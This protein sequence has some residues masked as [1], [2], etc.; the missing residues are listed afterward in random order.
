[1][2]RL[3][4]LAKEG[5]QWES[6][7]DLWEGARSL[8]RPSLSVLEELAKAYEHRLHNL[9]EAMERAQ[10]GLRQVESRRA[11]A[12]PA[13]V[14]ERQEWLHRIERLRKKIEAQK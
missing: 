2:T 14:R 3:A 7:V 9:G 8:C 10:E 4:G 1:M 13:W 11:L 5:R 12:G 6:A